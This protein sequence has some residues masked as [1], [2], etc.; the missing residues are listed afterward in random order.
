MAGKSQ[1][2]SHL[3]LNNQKSEATE[4]YKGTYKNTRDWQWVYLHLEAHLK[5]LLQK[6]ILE[7][8]TILWREKNYSHNSMFQGK[9]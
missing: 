8:I 3:R 2:C 7:S 1:V 9:M 5:T 4:Y 6:R